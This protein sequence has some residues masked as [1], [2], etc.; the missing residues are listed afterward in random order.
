MNLGSIELVHVSKLYHFVHDSTIYVIRNCNPT[1]CVGFQLVNMIGTWVRAQLGEIWAPHFDSTYARPPHHVLFKYVPTSVHAT[2]Y[3]RGRC[4]SVCWTMSI[5]P[6][7]YHPPTHPWMHPMCG[8]VS[9]GELAIVTTYCL[10]SFDP[11]SFGVE[12]HAS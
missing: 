3:R 12:E 6:P 2:T 5:H 7:T 10:V 8:S 9:G 1:R 4:G 11:C